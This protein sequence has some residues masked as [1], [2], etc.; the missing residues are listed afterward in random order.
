MKP[1]KSISDPRYVKAMSHPLR[2]R[3]IALLDERRGS[4]KELA[5]LLGISIGVVSYHVR[6]LER[7][8][9]VELVGEARRRGAIQHFY[10]STARPEVTD[11]AWAQASPIAKQAAV[12]S[13]L[14]VIDAYA[15]ASAAAGGFDRSDAAL[16]RVS[17]KVDGKGWTQ[18]ARAY[19][20]FIEQT[21]KIEASAAVRVERDP[22]AEDVVDVGMVLM[23][24]EAASL[25]ASLGQQASAESKPRRRVSSDV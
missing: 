23:L 10:R 4:P 9:L 6:A 12:G 21:E 3:I 2:V 11:E 18:L 16:V 24:F 8:G 19:A 14:Q 17:L 22:H 7:F 15:R 5:E 13:S 1:I 25:A 20:K